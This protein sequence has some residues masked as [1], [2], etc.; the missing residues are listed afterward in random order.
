MIVVW[1]HVFYSTEQQY[2]ILASQLESDV[3]EKWLPSEYVFYNLD[4]QLV[5]WNMT[6]VLEF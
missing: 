4:F 6:Q 5:L 3:R 2:N 1:C